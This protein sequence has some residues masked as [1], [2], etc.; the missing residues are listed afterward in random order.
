MNCDL[1]QLRGRVNLKNQEPID[2]TNHIS[3]LIKQNKPF[4]NFHCHKDNEKNKSLFILRYIISQKSQIFQ[5]TAT[6]HESACQQKYNTSNDRKKMSTCQVES[7]L[8]VLTTFT[9]F[10]CHA[11][12]MSCMIV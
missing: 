1:P 2:S 6:S 4:V 11:I 3:A 9:S 12:S 10:E 5:S 8:R 7:M